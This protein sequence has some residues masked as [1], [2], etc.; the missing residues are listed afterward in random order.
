MRVEMSD[1]ARD[2]LGRKEDTAY[3][4]RNIFLEG[5]KFLKQMKD[6]HPADKIN[7]IEAT[8]MLM[9]DRAK[10][11]GRQNF[12]ERRASGEDVSETSHNMSINQVNTSINSTVLETSTD[13][14]L[15]KSNY[16]AQE[17]KRDQ[18]MAKMI[19]NGSY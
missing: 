13:A 11:K 9:K 19:R 4:G 14:Y 5:E 10:S 8:R 7:K 15:K 16:E 3:L 12:C 2:I 18:Q 17:K 6:H 1:K